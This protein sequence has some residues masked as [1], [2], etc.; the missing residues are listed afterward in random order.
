MQNIKG[1]SLLLLGS[2]VYKDMIKQIADHY[3]L[4]LL[5]AGLYPGVLDEIADESYRIDTTDANVMIPFIQS[6]QIDG[7]YMGASEFIISSTCQYINQIGLPCVCTK[8]Q[9][10]LLQDKRS[11]KQLCMQFE[12]PVAPE[13]NFSDAESLTYPVIVKPVDGSGSRGVTD[14]GSYEELQ[15]AYKIAVEMSKSHRAIIEKKVKNFAIYAY[16]T[17]CDGEYFLEA[18]EDTYP[19]QEEQGSYTKSIYLAPSYLEPQFKQLFDEKIKTMLQS[20][21]IRNGDIWFEVFY[22][23]GFYYFNECGMRPA[24]HKSMYPVAYFTGINQ[25]ATSIHYALTGKGHRIT[26]PSLLPPT[27][28][29]EKKRYCT[30]PI[31]GKTGVIKE[32]V[33]NPPLYEHPNVVHIS[34]QRNVGDNIK[35]DKDFH[36]IIGFIHFVYDDEE[37]CMSMIQLIHQSIKMT[38]T[39]G[40]DMIKRSFHGLEEMISL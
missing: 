2:N 39:E 20:L 35:N 19:V 6:H 36:S 31:H 3:E 17:I 11:F 24:G 12:L 4:K 15:E 8:E 10:D 34:L 38:D 33:I 22:D 16:Y 25:I 21:G 37:E 23:N 14:C 18:T 29:K 28:H 26:T 40:K 30:Y 5:F 7:V 32:I 1:K 9:W 27:C 13:Y